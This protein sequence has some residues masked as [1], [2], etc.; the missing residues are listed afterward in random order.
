MGVFGGT[1]SPSLHKRPRNEYLVIYFGGQS[2]EGTDPGTGKVAAAEMASHMKITYT[3]VWFYDINMANTNAFALYTAGANAMGW[4]D[5]TLYIL[6]KVYKKIYVVKR[7]VGG[8]KIATV[9]EASSYPRADFINR[10]NAAKPIIAT[11]LGNN[12]FDVLNLWG[13]CESDALLEADS[14]AYKANFESWVSDY[15]AAT[16]LDNIWIIKKMNNMT[17][18]FPYRANVEAQQLAIAAANPQRFKVVDTDNMRML[19]TN[20]RAGDTNRGDF[21]H[22]RR[23]TTIVVGNRFA[24]AVLT[25]FGRVKQDTTAPVIQSA[26][27]NSAGTTLTLT[28]DEALHPTVDPFW[29]QFVVGTKVW[30]SVVVT[31]STIVLTPTIPFYSSSSYTLS[32]TKNSYF[33]EN[34]QDLQGNEAADLVNYSITNNASTTEPT[35]TTLYTADFSGGV[36]ANWSSP[37]GGT[38]S[39]PAT[40]ANGETNCIMNTITAV[41]GIAR[42]QK[43][44]TTGLTNGNVYRCRFRVEVPD[45]MGVPA[46]PS[47]FYFQ[48]V[49]PTPTVSLLQADRLILRDQ[50]TYIETQFTYTSTG[51][52]HMYFEISNGAIGPASWWLKDFIIEKVG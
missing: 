1:F 11:E 5:Q 7:A 51:S 42:L 32:Y 21:S 26:V 49:Q 16:G 38:V 24:D 3:N 39:A 27:I 28:Y 29:K 34:L 15:K 20:L 31:G 23:S 14:L 25:V 18:D 13:Q 17:K 43:S 30:S 47:A 45:L 41:N 33:R 22:F 2:N 44:L 52:G 10:S 9:G 4:I 40:S 37:I 12:K 36:P 6:S 19:G 8:T 50:M 35:I 48:L 46:N